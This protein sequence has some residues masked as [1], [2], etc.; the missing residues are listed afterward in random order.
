MSAVD[1]D[2]SSIPPATAGAPDDA[3]ARPS[4][5]QLLYGAG[6]GLGLAAL[7]PVLRPA[8]HLQGAAAGEGARVAAH[9][10]ADRSLDFGLDWKFVLVNPNGTNDPTGAYTR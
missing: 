8:G 2:K 10:A 5:R 3:A 1:R 9:A 4:R 6:A 7:A